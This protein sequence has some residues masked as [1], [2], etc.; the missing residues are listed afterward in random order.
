[1][2]RDLATHIKTLFTQ[3]THNIFIQLFRYVFVGGVAFLIDFGLLFF[4]TEY[5][6][7]PYVLSATISFIGG[8]IVN[9]LLSVKWVFNSSNNS[10]SVRAVEFF[11]FALI[12]IIGLGIN[13][14]I[15]W[16][17][18][19]FLD[20]HYLISKIFSTIIV[21]LWNFLARRTMFSNF[22]EKWTS[23]Q[24]TRLS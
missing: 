2:G 16:S 19:E 14:L 5:V 12:G 18:T 21:F 4:L 20:F 24:Q 11:L 10:D 9:Y 1:M 23:W 15:I 7:L 6:L 17:F 8:L 13:A 3:P 22:T